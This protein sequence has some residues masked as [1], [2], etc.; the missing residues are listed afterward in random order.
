MRRSLLLFTLVTS[1]IL[2]SF[3]STGY[4][5]KWMRLE[6]EVV[7]MT[8]GGESIV[9]IYVGEGVNNQ[10]V[11]LTI[12]EKPEWVNYSFSIQ[13]ARTPFLS[14]LTIKIS[15]KAPTGN[16][17]IRIGVWMGR[18]LLEEE[19]V[20]LSILPEF[21]P[22]KLYFTNHTCPL[23]ILIGEK[24]PLDLSFRYVI[25]YET[26][27]RVKILLDEQIETMVEF[28]LSGNGSIPMY[29]Q[30]IAPTEP[31]DIFITS[32]I[33]YFNPLN[34]TWVISESKTCRVTVTTIP[35]V[36]KII[37]KGLPTN[38]EVNLQMLI[39]PQGSV[40]ERKISSNKEHEVNLSIY[41][42]STILVVVEDEIILSNNTKYVAENNLREIYVEPGW[43]ITV[44]FS[45]ST[46]YLVSMR[47]EPN[48]NILKI[49]EKDIWI[50]RGSSFPISPPKIFQSSSKKYI[51]SWISVDGKIVS[52]NQVL[53]IYSP[54]VITYRYIEY[55]KLTVI[56]EV[57]LPST[58]SSKEYFLQDLLSYVY[59]SSGEYWV[60]SGEIVEIPY[61]RYTLNDYRFVPT[62][63]ESNLKIEIHG[64]SASVVVDEAGFIKLYYNVEVKINIG[65]SYSRV[66][67]IWKDE[68]IPLGSQY[69][70]QLNKLLSP[71]TIGERIELR[72]F[73]SDLSYEY[74][75]GEEKIILE[76]NSPGNVEIQIDR[77]FL[78]K[79]YP[80][81]SL[82]KMYPSCIGPPDLT[83]WNRG[84]DFT[85][86]W[87]L[88]KTPLTCYFPEKIDDELTSILFIRGYVGDTEY[89]TSGLKSFYVVKPLIIRMEYKMVRYF[90][91]RGSTDRGTF[92]G[93][94]IYPERA[95][96]AWRVEPQ[97][98]YAEG[99]LGLLGFKW[100]AS[101][102]YGVEYIDGD[103][104]VEI[105]WVL[106]PS[107]DSPIVQFLELTSIIMI[108]YIAYKYRKMWKIKMR[109]SIQG[110][111]DVEY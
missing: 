106:T 110:E 99:I 34:G 4:S 44:P 29:R 76:V 5:V 32:I 3:F 82:Q 58:V 85:E 100:R 43:T 49:L 48:E 104:V 50:K 20:M 88:E 68:W 46:L 90:Q 55:N 107:I 17:T 2:F 75:R 33:E 74:I 66:E 59:E 72:S 81:P 95:Q 8:P 47:V 103:K 6:P 12:L 69:N 84:E 14:N 24:I 31:R 40:I 97:E 60:K 7:N 62:S 86:L 13:E 9:K 54:P 36:F 111:K 28:Q 94:G 57:K 15:S 26:R 10:R 64:D 102:P 89:T 37:V 25:A 61:R 39:L 109:A 63:F 91:L 79:I 38:L 105:V 56:S 93:G 21:T 45:Y 101:N 27:I 41:Q 22:P 23:T 78:V 65:V 67:T 1:L 80:V 52:D 87:V 42:P 53:E 11:R 35:T 71:R 51:L 30:I 70:I 96:A 83:G 108:T 77:Y 16:Y 92:I 19:K 73:K 18:T 98:Y